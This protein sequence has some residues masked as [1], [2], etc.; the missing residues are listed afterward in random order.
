MSASSTEK[1]MHY[2]VIVIALG[3]RHQQVCATLNPAPSRLNPAPSTLNPA[4]S[5]LNPRS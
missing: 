2:G 5:T 1:K 3:A 4:P